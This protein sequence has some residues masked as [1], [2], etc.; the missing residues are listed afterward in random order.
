MTEEEEKLQRAYVDGRNAARSGA[1]SIPPN[2]LTPL[3]A[4]N[5]KVGYDDVYYEEEDSHYGRRL[6]SEI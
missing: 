2:Y 5:W 6:D 4:I 3:E 1:S